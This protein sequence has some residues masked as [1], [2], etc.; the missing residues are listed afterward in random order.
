MVAIWAL[1]CCRDLRRLQQPKHESFETPTKGRGGGP[2]RSCDR[3]C[4]ARATS[5]CTGVYAECLFVV[6]WGGGAQ[7]DQLTENFC[8]DAPR[9]HEPPQ[10]IL[11]P[12]G[13]RRVFHHIHTE[14]PCSCSLGKVHGGG[15]KM[16]K[17]KGFS[18]RLKG[19]RAFSLNVARGNLFEIC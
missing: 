13:T 11:L 15:G 10:L 18:Q 12:S 3:K 8:C 19:M 14:S 5:Q 17:P 6:V 7:C 4:I 16:Q 1:A 2:S 9:L